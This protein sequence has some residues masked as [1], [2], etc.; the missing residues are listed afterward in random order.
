[1]KTLLSVLLLV[2]ILAAPVFAENA[3]YQ[4]FADESSDRYHKFPPVCKPGIKNEA[5]AKE[6]QLYFKDSQEAE[7]KG[8]VPC[9]LCHRVPTAGNFN[10]QT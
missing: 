2:G 4:E 1:M 10:S 7:S 5:Y 6:H 3:I 8:F 9:K